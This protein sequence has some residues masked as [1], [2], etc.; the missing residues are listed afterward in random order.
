LVVTALPAGEPAGPPSL[1]VQPEEL[2]DGNDPCPDG[3]PCDTGLRG[4]CGPGQ[5]RLTGNEF[6]CMQLQEATSETCDGLDND[7]DALIDE[8]D[9]CNCGGQEGCPCDEDRDCLTGS[10]CRRPLGNC[11]GAGL[12]VTIPAGGCQP[13]LPVCGCD[14][15]TYAS[16]CEARLAGQSLVLERACPAPCE[17]CDPPDS[18]AGAND[19]LCR[20]DCTVCGDGIL[21]PGEECDDGNSI[22]TDGCRN[23]CALPLCSDQI[24]DSAESCDPPG[25]PAGP[26][27]NPCRANCTVCGDALPD[28]AEECDDGNTVDTDACANDCAAAAA[29]EIPPISLKVDLTPG[30]ALELSWGPSCGAI[31]DDYCVYQGVPGDFTSHLPVICS[32][33]GTTT[34]TLTLPQGD[35]YFLVVPRNAYREGSYGRAWD[36]AERPPGQSACVPQKLEGCP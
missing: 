33:G 23:S 9:V 3:E 29:G 1:R 15:V 34:V 31:D 22:D 13:G 2:C 4:E 12:C 17:T 32:T 10:F 28:L 8:E 21:D 7:C 16:D 30:G 26:S 20:N 35:A 27:G 14:G 24:V 18:P 19:N 6:V 25:I 11:I 36:G 5:L